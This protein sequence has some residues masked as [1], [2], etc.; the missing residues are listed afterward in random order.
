[1]AISYFHIALQRLIANEK[2]YSDRS[3]A[4]YVSSLLQPASIP[5]FKS[6]P[7]FRDPT[8][9]S[10]FCVCQMCLLMTLFLVEAAPGIGTMTGKQFFSVVFPALASPSCTGVHSCLSANF[11]NSKQARVSIPYP[12]ATRK[13][14][15]PY[16]GKHAKT[17][18]VRVT[19][20]WRQ[21]LRCKSVD[22]SVG[23]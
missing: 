1:M 7:L 12:A 2:S 13:G 6:R 23:S 4:E 10:Q 16:H 17:T 19:L 9:L 20:V 5:N 18:N 8:D 11:S 22:T 3:V 21:N 15:R 14:S